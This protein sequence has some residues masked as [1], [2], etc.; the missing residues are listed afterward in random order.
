[1]NI[2]RVIWKIDNTNKGV[3][4]VNAPTSQ[5]AN[6]S[7]YNK[8]KGVLFPNAS[9]QEFSTK[10][11]IINTGLVHVDKVLEILNNAIRHNPAY[12]SNNNNL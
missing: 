5:A 6:T 11:A 8:V 3:L 12:F 2:F 4:F 1:M 7:A 9:N 10:F